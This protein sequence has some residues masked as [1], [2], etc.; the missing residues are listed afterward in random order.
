MARCSNIAGQ[1]KLV[2]KEHNLKSIHNKQF[3]LAPK[4]RLKLVFKEHNLKSIH[5]SFRTVSAST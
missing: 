5:N 4:G 1:L 3:A 2:F